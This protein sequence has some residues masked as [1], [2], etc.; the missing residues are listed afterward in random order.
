MKFNAN[1]PW[2]VVGTL[3][4]T[5]TKK[6]IHW[7]MSVPEN[8]FFRV[9]QVSPTIIDLSLY[10]RETGEWKGK[11]YLSH[12]GYG[13]CWGDDSFEVLRLGDNDP[14]EVEEEKE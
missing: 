3:L 12:L 2:A 4:L 13:E 5:S 8:V 7:M 11:R 9:Q 14:K 6:P 1:V 10:D